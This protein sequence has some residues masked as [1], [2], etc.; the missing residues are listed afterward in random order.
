MKS[1]VCKY[2]GKTHL[3]IENLNFK[4]NKEAEEYATLNCDCVEGEEYRHLAKS[5]DNLKKFL[6]S[7]SYSKEI[8]EFLEKC[9]LHIISFPTD[10]ITYEFENI[11][12]K[13]KIVKGNF[14]IQRI[15]T[16]K[17]IKII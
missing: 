3:N 14:T 4:T 10:V 17:D 9:G 6:N 7:T 5:K 12:I 13:F 2:C 8:K 11:K 15:W 1:L 16:D